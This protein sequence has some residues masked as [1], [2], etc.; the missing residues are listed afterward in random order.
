MRSTTIFKDQKTTWA[1]Y[2]GKNGF[3]KILVFEKFQINTV[4]FKK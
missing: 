3:R 1:P 4:A 2:K